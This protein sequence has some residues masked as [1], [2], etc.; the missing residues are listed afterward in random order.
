M[1][2][3]PAATWSRSRRRFQLSMI[4]RRCELCAVAPPEPGRPVRR[5]ELD[6]TLGVEQLLANLAQENADPL[7][8]T[9]DEEHARPII[10][11]HAVAAPALSRL[12]HLPEHRLED[13]PPISEP[14]VTDE[15]G[16]GRGIINDLGLDRCDRDR[17][18]R[19]VAAGEPSLDRSDLRCSK[20]RRGEAPAREGKPSPDSL[21]ER[22][23]RDRS[24]AQPKRTDGAASG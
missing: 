19:L 12:Q 7:F 5:S 11:K 23:R 9:D 8:G 13:Q 17:P 1:A 15:V 3:A 24:M 14:V 16:P 22:T 4:T 20:P 2:N 6:R 10:V 18:Q 21:R